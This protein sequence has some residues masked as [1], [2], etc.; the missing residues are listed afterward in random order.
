MY[1]AF[2]FD[3]NIEKTILNLYKDCGP[4]IT[5]A[6]GKVTFSTTTYRSIAN[7]S[8]NVGYDVGSDS[9]QCLSS[10]SWEIP[11]C[12]IKGNTSLLKVLR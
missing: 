5:V 7:V 11:T 10:G 3:S 6:D 2:K 12:T 9:I 4:N 1:L 8:C